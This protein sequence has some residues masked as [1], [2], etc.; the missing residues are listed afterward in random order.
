MMR[1]TAAVIGSRRSKAAVGGPLYE[2]GEER[3][4]ASSLE[5]CK[6]QGGGGPDCRACVGFEHGSRQEKPPRAARPCE[7]EF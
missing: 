7:R 3:A 6:S 4:T 1:P 2:P 5:N